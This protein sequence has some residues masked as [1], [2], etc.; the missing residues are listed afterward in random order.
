MT[1][2]NETD[3]V[4]LSLDESETLSEEEIKKRKKR[5]RE[6][7]KL[8]K[9]LAGGD[10]SKT[11]T[12]VA[13]VLNLY[14]RARNSDITLAI[15]YWETFQSDIY[16]SDSISPKDLFKL[17][18]QNDITRARQKIQNEYGLFP[19]DEKIKRFRKKNEVN[20]RE[21]V[22]NDDP[23]QN[24]INVF[25]DE[26]GK[27]DEFTIVASVW[28]LE[29]RSIYDLFRKIMDWQEGSLNFKKQEI[30]FTKIRDKHLEE[31]EEYI[32]LIYQNSQY[33][34][35]KAIAIQKSKTSRS[36]SEL[37]E[38]LH[39]HLIVDGIN[40]EV[41]SSRVTLPHRLNIT[42]DEEQSLD[43]LTLKELGERIDHRLSHLGKDQS[44]V[45]QLQTASS[46]KTPLIQLADVLAGALHRH[47]NHP[48][49]ET[50][51]DKASDLVMEYFEVQNTESDLDDADTA[52]L[53]KVS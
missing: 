13:H 31:F 29:P 50:A 40:H 12:K 3:E 6:K 38:K 47:L 32:K 20:M 5:E 17:E 23:P 41:T 14:R 26:T 18:R 51:K 49:K 4:P 16:N 21:E 30:H 42:L 48:G 39:E 1:N 7:Q 9:S 24:F 52:I 11:K 22:L 43:A 45:E 37:V 53:F 2:G 15:K 34:S 46:K 8:L 28:I 19:P 33:L 27:D 36:V 35:F 10:F 25:S 44:K